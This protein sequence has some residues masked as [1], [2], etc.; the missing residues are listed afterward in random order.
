MIFGCWDF[1]NV[2]FL[3]FWMFAFFGLLD[4]WLCGCLGTKKC[5]SACC[6]GGVS[7]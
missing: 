7:T 3:D 1:C 5:I 6:S 4:L 2:G